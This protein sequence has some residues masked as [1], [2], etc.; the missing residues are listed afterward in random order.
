MAFICKKLQSTWSSRERL[1]SSSLVSLSGVRSLLHIMPEGH[2]SWETFIF[3]LKDALD[4]DLKVSYPKKN[5]AYVQYHEAINRNRIL[6]TQQL[7]QIS[8]ISRW[9]KKVSGGYISY[10]PLYTAISK[11][12]SRALENRLVV[13]G[14][15]FG[16]GGVTFTGKHRCVYGGRS[17]I[18]P[19]E[20]CPRLPKRR[21]GDAMA[22]GTSNKV[23]RSGAV[24]SCTD[25]AA[26]TVISPLLPELP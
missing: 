10:D 24:P 11:W 16:G 1:S 22:K 5:Q 9:V 8:R 19:A 26:D 17:F 14:V 23:K 3:S 6:L 18:P 2:N 15:R 25:I 12:Q 7:G 13:V 20:V 21:G 4:V